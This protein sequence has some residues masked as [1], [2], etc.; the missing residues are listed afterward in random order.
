MRV[1]VSGI[2]IDMHFLS[3]PFR[4]HQSQANASTLTSIFAR[5]IPTFYTSRVCIC[6]GITRLLHSSCFMQV[7]MQMQKRLAFA[8]ELQIYV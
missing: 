3:I 5:F 6:H 2:E 4:S 8:C 1:N 7:Q